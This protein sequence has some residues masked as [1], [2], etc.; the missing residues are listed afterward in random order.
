MNKYNV[1]YA[2]EAYFTEEGLI[3]NSDVRI[4]CRNPQCNC[5]PFVCYIC[6]VCGDKW[7]GHC[8]RGIPPRG[9][10]TP[11]WKLQQDITDWV[12]AYK[13]S[14]ENLVKESEEW[15][16]IFAYGIEPKYYC[17]HPNEPIPFV[18][19]VVDCTC[20]TRLKGVRCGAPDIKNCH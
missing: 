12:L 11:C 10:C 14:H 3:C 20:R 7:W 13:V 19:D 2:P 6:K 8:R 17:Y 4:R 18:I 9:V 16:K 1:E 5:Y 15:W